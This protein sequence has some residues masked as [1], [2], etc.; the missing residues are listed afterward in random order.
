MFNALCSLVIIVGF[1]VILVG[2]KNKDRVGGESV[3]NT[4]VMR[5]V[6]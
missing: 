5:L 1:S 3:T 6:R 2:H 4:E